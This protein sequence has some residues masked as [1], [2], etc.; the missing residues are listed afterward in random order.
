MGREGREDVARVVDSRWVS[1][2]SAAFAAYDGCYSGQVGWY[3]SSNG[4]GH[5]YGFSQNNTNY[6]R[7]G[8]NDRILRARTWEK[9]GLGVLLYRSQDYT[10]GSSW[11]LRRDARENN[12]QPPAAEFD[13]WACQPNAK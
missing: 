1:S 7:Y 5:C 10:S 6:T 2:V 9:S 13:K 11:C 3:T 4:G 12:P 8:I